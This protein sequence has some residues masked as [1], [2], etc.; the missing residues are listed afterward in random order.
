MSRILAKA[1]ILWDVARRGQVSVVVGELRK[2]LWSDA[3]AFGL[4]RDLT[5][6][7]DAPAALLPIHVRPLEPAD[8]QR[9]FTAELAASADSSGDSSYAYLLKNR[10]AF[11]GKR[12]PTCYVA[13]TQENEPCYMQWLIGPESND[14]IRRYFRGMFPKLERDE[15]LLEYAFTV[16]R[17]QGKRIMPAAMARIAQKGLESGAARAITFVDTD[18]AAALKGCERAGFVPYLK[19]ITSC[20]LMRRSVRFEPLAAADG[21]RRSA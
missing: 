9:L 12:I 13:V 3:V 15:R 17:F 4:E 8:E 18:N 16:R 2:W 11:L 21:A 1:K 7:F 10:L 20:R 6:P 5:K 19:R 14:Q